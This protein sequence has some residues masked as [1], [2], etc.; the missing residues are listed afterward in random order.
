[1]DGWK[2]RIDCHFLTVLL[3]NHSLPDSP[4]Q[5]MEESRLLQPKMLHHAIHSQGCVWSWSSGITYRWR[6]CCCLFGL[7]Q[8]SIG[9]IPQ[10]GAKWNFRCNLCWNQLM[11]ARHFRA[12]WSTSIVCSFTQYQIGAVSGRTHVKDFKYGIQSIN[13]RIDLA[14]PDRVNSII[15]NW[16]QG[17][18]H[19]LPDLN[20]SFQIAS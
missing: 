20:I 19:I 15:I 8:N 5:L 13:L 14:P 2:T 1:M 7:V 4:K 10:L 16:R 11:R 17:H 18:P 12:P 6:C 3:R 9:K